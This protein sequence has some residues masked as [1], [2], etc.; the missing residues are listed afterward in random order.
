MASLGAGVMRRLWMI[1]A[2]LFQGLAWLFRKVS[3]GCALMAI[4]LAALGDKNTKL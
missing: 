1:P 4:A 3:D 2:K